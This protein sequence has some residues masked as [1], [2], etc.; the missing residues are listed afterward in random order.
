MMVAMV[1]VTAEMIVQTTSEGKYELITLRNTAETRAVD[2]P[3][4][5]TVTS[6]ESYPL[7]QI[8]PM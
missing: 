3:D 4:S 7:F 2:M 5:M 6:L 1:L 8:I